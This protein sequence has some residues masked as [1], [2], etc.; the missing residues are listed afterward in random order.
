MDILRRHR[1]VIVYSP[2]GKLEQV[3]SQVKENLSLNLGE[4]THREKKPGSSLNSGKTHGGTGAVPKQPPWMNSA[5]SSL[6]GAPAKAEKRG[7]R[8]GSACTA[9]SL[10]TARLGDPNPFCRSTLSFLLLVFKS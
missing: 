3:P 7:R 4:E 2:R 1:N 8:R 9:P 10:L 5:G 6:Q